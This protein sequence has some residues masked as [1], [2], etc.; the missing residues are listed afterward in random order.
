MKLGMGNTQNTFKAKYKKEKPAKE[1][2]IIDWHWQHL[3]CIKSTRKFLRMTKDNTEKKHYFFCIY[4]Y[5]NDQP[6]AF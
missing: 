6:E 5:T 4:I 1:K 2:I 3:I